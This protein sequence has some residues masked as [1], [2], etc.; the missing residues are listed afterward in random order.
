MTTIIY[1]GCDI[2]RGGPISQA[3]L[4]LLAQ[5]LHDAEMPRGHNDWPQG[6]DT[7]EK[8]DRHEKAYEAEVED[9]GGYCNCCRQLAGF[10]LSKFSITERAG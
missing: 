10:I 6:C 8:R 1:D 5:A 4:D 7:P 3:D 2:V 9:N